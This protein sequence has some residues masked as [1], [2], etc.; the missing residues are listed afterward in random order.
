METE[1]NM[2][3]EKNVPVPSRIN[4]SNSKH[5][6]INTLVETWEVGDSVAFK[7][8]KK[9]KGSAK[10]IYSLEAQA[11]LVKSKNAGQRTTSRM[12]NDEGIVRV[13]RVA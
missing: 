6:K 10:S 13:W 11:L 9:P 7:L 1:E 4:K 2:I 3:I 12:I 8:R 5:S